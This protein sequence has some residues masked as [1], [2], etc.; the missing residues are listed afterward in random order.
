MNFEAEVL[1][2]SCKGRVLVEF[3][4]R[5]AADFSTFLGQLGVPV[6]RVEA[7]EAPQ[8]V[9]RYAPAL[10]SLVLFQNRH[11]TDGLSGPPSEKSVQQFLHTLGLA[12]G[13]STGLLETAHAALEA[14][15]FVQAAQLFAQAAQD[16]EG[17]RQDK[18]LAGLALCY[19][20]TGDVAR[21]QETLNAIPEAHR[22]S[23][24]VKR[25]QAQVTLAHQAA[26]LSRTTTQLQA[27]LA[28]TPQD[29][30][31]RFDLALARHK[32]GSY[33]EAVAALLEIVKEAPRW[34][35]GA[36]RRQLLEFFE[37][38]GPTHEATISG[39]R[40]LSSLLFR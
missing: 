40:K 2:A 32:D 3:Y 14:G 23:P 36:A 39:R 10:P 33:E 37:A 26:H 15:D 31:A 30:Q 19:A 29:H 6:V 20:R 11:P 27:H 9:Q 18:A 35:D 24:E 34:N 38:Y 13:H 4:A 21:A 28:H 7:R 25:V 22:H 16:S 5:G 1:E 12:T 17:T 8:S